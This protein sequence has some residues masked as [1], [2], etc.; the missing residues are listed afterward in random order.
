MVTDLNALTPANSNLLRSQHRESIGCVCHRRRKTDAVVTSIALPG[1][2]VPTQ[3]A[4]TPDGSQAYVTG[5]GDV[6]LI[7][8]ATNA[9]ATT[10]PV[11][12]GQA[13]HDVAF[14][15]DG[16]RAYVTCGNTS[17]IYVLDTTSYKVVGQ[18]ASSYPAG[19]AIARPR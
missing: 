2:D 6:W 13:L 9:V 15:P 12:D 4:L 5:E 14:A 16:S 19:L 18:I 1:D 10:I 17:A 8:T 11:T 3:I 7:H